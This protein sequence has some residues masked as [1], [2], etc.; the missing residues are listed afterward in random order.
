MMMTNAIRNLIRENKVFQIDIVLQSGKQQGMVTL[1]HS[2]KEAIYAGYIDKTKGVEL[3]NDPDDLLEFLL[4]EDAEALAK[5]RETREKAAAAAKKER[6]T[7]L[8][9]E[10]AAGYGKDKKQP[11]TFGA[12]E[13]AEG[14]DDWF[15]Q[16][17]EWQRKQQDRMKKR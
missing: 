17:Q 3:A 15:K 2:I 9:E 12:Q 16:Q 7:A 8:R 10:V 1:E 6:E 14:E 4:E 5:D 13:T 11:I